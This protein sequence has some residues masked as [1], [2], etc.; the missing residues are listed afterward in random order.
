MTGQMML[1]GIDPPEFPQ[2]QRTCAAF[3]DDG[4]GFQNWGTGRRAGPRCRVT[5]CDRLSCK[6]PQGRGRKKMD[7]ISRQAAIDFIESEWREW[8]EEYGI[9]D[10][11]CD[12][13]D[14]PAAEP[15]IIRCKDCKW[16]G[17]LGCAIR[18]VD[19]TDKPTENDFCSFAERRNDE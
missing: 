5:D 12:L 4:I 6:K 10:V 17:E 3:E 9:T 1:P 16:F 19:D 8:G 18:I 13:D 14:M 7:L 11:L 15:E 2:C